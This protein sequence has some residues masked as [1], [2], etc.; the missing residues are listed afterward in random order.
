MQHTETEDLDIKTSTSGA[1]LR[2]KIFKLYKEIDGQEIQFLRLQ[3][4]FHNR[5]QSS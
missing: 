2:M 4:N 1:F 3:I 5:R